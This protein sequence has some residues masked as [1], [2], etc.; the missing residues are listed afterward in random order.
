MKRNEK[1]NLLFV[2]ESLQCGGAEKS[3]VNL[4]QNL[5]YRIFDVDLLLL[6]KKGEFLNVVPS[7][8][9]IVHKVVKHEAN[10]LLLSLFRV[11]YL[12]LRKAYSSKI[13]GAQLY[14]R[15][16]G[17]L[18]KPQSKNYDIAIAYN[19]GF[20]TYFVASKV[21]ANKKFA[22]LNTD[23]LKAGYSIKFD[24]K[25]YE[26]YNTVVCVSQESE[27]SLNKALKRIDKKLKTTVIEDIIDEEVIKKLS[28]NVIEFPIKSNKNTKIVT[29]ARLAKA[30]GI[31]LALKACKELKEKGENIIWYVVGDGPE[32]AD[33][34]KMILDYK[35]ENNFILLGFKENPYS[36]IKQCDIYVQTS[37]FEGLGL[38]LIE[39]KILKKAIVT[40]N[41]D[42]AHSIIEHEKDGLISTANPIEISECIKKYIDNDSFKNEILKN[43]SKK[44]QFDK[45]GSLKK[46]NDLLNS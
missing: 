8:V 17:S 14:W 43:I 23:Y 20:S 38:T 27:L 29:V 33:I 44:G 26:K 40:T 37:Y 2:I 36:Y 16:F 7:K 4:L 46:I 19:Q 3:L 9:N 25:F 45:N 31:D 34:E 41:F 24:Y 10:R 42:T 22:W 12:F 11:Y 1:I 18:I 21:K 35:L 28:E 30:K 39:A 32:R 6:N 5:D 15:S 13:H